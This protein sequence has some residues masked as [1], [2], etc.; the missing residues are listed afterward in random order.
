VSFCHV[1]FGTNALHPLP[2]ED[3]AVSAQPRVEFDGVSVVPPTAS[4]WFDEAGY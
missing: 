3:Q 4:T 1:G 2:P